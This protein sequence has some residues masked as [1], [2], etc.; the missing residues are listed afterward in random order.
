M[1]KPSVIV[2][3]IHYTQPSPHSSRPKSSTLLI[4]QKPNDL[5][6]RITRR[7]EPRCRTPQ[8]PR[9]RPV[10]R[11]GKSYDLRERNTPR[12]ITTTTAAAGAHCAVKGCRNPRSVR[13]WPK[14]GNESSPL[15]TRVACATIKR[16]KT[17][18]RGASRS[19][20]RRLPPCCANRAFAADDARG[21]RPALFRAAISTA[22]H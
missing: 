7:T 20:G 3:K 6:S 22:S 21:T 15:S 9:T 13:T 14:V 11:P 5:D 4:T 19:T 18:T 2:T 10:N 8:A 12:I 1:I 16:L 17:D